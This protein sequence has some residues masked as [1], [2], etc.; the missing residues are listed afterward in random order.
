[1][2]SG[3]SVLT[4]KIQR[5]MHYRFKE[6]QEMKFKDGLADGRTSASEELLSKA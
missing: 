1:M 3:K 4:Q 5:F 2:L 6:R